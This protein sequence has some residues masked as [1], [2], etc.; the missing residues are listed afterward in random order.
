MRP[1]VISPRLTQLV[2]PMKPAGLNPIRVLVAPVVFLVVGMTSGRDAFDEAAPAAA[3]LR[4]ESAQVTGGTPV[5]G[6]IQLDA[7]APAG[8]V[9]VVLQSSGPNAIV[10]KSLSLPAGTRAVAFVIT[11]KLVDEH[12][13]IRISARDGRASGAGVSGAV[14]PGSFGAPVFAEL[15]LVPIRLRNLTLAESAIVGGADVG[16]TVTLTHPAPPAGIRVMLR[17]NNGAATVP[18][19]VAVGS[20]RDRVDFA[21]NTR[22]VTQGTTVG[23][24]ATDLF[25]IPT[26]SDEG[27]DIIVGSSG[28][29]APGAV[30]AHLKIFPPPPIATFTL[31]PTRVRGGSNV[32]GSLLP[33]TGVTSPTVVSLTTD[34][35]DLVTMPASVT[36]PASVVPQPFTLHTAAVASP[37][38][39]T[40]K[41]R[42]GTGLSAQTLTSQ[43]TITP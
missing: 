23:I 6:Q 24:S 8:G 25:L 18:F 34:R 19:S 21:V 1:S 37:T 13:T 22:I 5:R 20:G 26:S 14:P 28:P 2:V 16:A 4:L 32:I 31:R 17:S 38:L 43:V 41:A 30:T 35:P 15:T 36:I 40:V 39:V 29:S 11:T 9:L 42:A 7:P 33:A 12:E 27:Q 10:P 3:A